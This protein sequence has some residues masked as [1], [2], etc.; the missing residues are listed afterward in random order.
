MSDDHGV[1]NNRGDRGTSNRGA[2]FWVSAVAGWA[3]IGWGLR[4]A[5]HHHVDTRP[6]SMARFF[7]GGALIHDL[8]FAPVVLAGGVVLARLVRGPARALVQAA[9][10]ISGTVVLFAYPE[11]R[12][13][14]H[15][16]HNPT[17]LP[18]NYTVTTAIVVGVVLAG[19]LVVAI[20]RGRASR[21]RRA[22][23]G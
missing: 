16:L 12:G 11:I 1:A 23:R 20:G 8:L 22:G 13:Y 10:I 17:S 3:L 14:A 15:A 9:L 4:G 7:L 5:L 6:A 2:L 21:A 19:V 18:H